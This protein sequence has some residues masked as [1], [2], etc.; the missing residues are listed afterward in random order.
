M[1]RGEQWYLGCLASV[2]TMDVKHKSELNSNFSAIILNR[3]TLHEL[4]F[5][6]C[7]FKYQGN[8]CNLKC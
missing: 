3:G 8:S 2:K 4:S 7:I 1:C 5:V 6:S